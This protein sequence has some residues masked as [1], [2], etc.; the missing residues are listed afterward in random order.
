MYFSK[1]LHTEEPF[2]MLSGNKYASF[3]GMMKDSLLAH[4][5]KIE[6]GHVMAIR[7]NVGA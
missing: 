7:V 3:K 4:M 6:C 1:G 2:A 5:L